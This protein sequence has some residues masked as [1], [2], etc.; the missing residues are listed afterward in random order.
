MLRGRGR[1]PDGRG[2]GAH[3]RVLHTVREVPSDRPERPVGG[4]QP[5]GAAVQGSQTPTDGADG[6]PL[7]PADVRVR[8]DEPDPRPAPVHRAGRRLRSRFRRVRVAAAGRPV[9]RQ[10][11]WS[12]GGRPLP[13]HARPGKLSAAQFAGLGP[14]HQ[15]HL[16]QRQHA[17]HDAPGARVLLGLDDRRRGAPFAAGAGNERLQSGQNPLRD[18][19]PEEAASLVSVQEQSGGYILSVL[20]D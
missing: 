8:T 20:P 14:G 17:G 2:E 7:C 15:S 4:R 18:N 3:S 5:H 1:R 9:P 16:A 19:P 10:R 13:E 12:S 11:R 6:G